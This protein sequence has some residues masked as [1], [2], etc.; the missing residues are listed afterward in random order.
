MLLD[1]V[2]PERRVRSIKNADVRLPAESQDVVLPGITGE[3]EVL[4]GHAPFITLLGTGILSFEANGK[5]VRLMVSGGFAEVDRDKV[6]VM[7]EAAALP[8]EVEAGA[9][10]KSLAEL[11]RKL[12]ELGSVA[13]H[14]EE[15]NR[16]R[17]EAE[18]AAAK[19][20]LLK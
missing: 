9:E 13:T 8:E 16:L 18:R 2:T 10:A 7:C 19:L 5:N 12:M 14:D 11:E 3:F 6:T 15:L 4:P 20:R 1:I 17:A